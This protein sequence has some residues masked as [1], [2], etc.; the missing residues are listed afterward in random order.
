[1]YDVVCCT[2]IYNACCSG[3]QWGSYAYMVCN[4][5]VPYMGYGPSPFDMPFNGQ[6][7]PTDMYGTQ[8]YMPGFSPP[9]QR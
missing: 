8:G 4:G 2:C 6:I 1:M 5:S 7:M 3:A 9:V